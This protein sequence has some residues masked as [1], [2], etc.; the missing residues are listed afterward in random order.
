[1]LGHD[2]NVRAGDVLHR[3]T[4][5]KLVLVS[6]I[7]RDSL[8]HDL[9]LEVRLRSQLAADERSLILD[10]L[11][12]QGYTLLVRVVLDAVL[13][14]PSG[15]RQGA[16]YE[17]DVA[18]EY[19]PQG[20]VV[21]VGGEGF[22]GDGLQLVRRDAR[23]DLTS[24]LLNLN[25]G[26][27]KVGLVGS[28]VCRFHGLR[29]PHGVAVLFP[30]LRVAELGLE[31]LLRPVLVYVA[32]ED[33]RDARQVLHERV[34]E[35]VLGG[36]LFSGEA[37]DCRIIRVALVRVRSTADDA[38]DPATAHERVLVVARLHVADLDALARLGRLDELPVTDVQPDVIRTADRLVGIEEHHV[39]GLEVVHRDGL[40]LA[41]LVICG[42]G[43]R[44]AKVLVDLLHQA[45]AVHSSGEAVAS[46]LV[47]SAEELLSVG[48]NVIATNSHY[49]PPIIP[50]SQ[51]MPLV[52]A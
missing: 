32:S 19:V 44:Q 5:L 18:A 34:R 38:R 22:L 28:G 24:E 20:T 10:R 7:R 2:L 40:A 25:L 33:I 43:N 15:T 45:G 11:I 52:A 12:V 41:D 51:F 14:H 49:G 42:A 3:L 21:H 8:L 46:P 26:S 6:G 39:A 17:L 37:S 29:L 30:P 48:R 9:L 16:A 47:R 27:L 35:A 23:S 36:Q 50:S 1:M 31:L 4:A 13:V